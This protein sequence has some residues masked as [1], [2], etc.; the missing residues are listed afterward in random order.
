MYTER[1]YRRRTAFTLLEVLVV[2]TVISTVVGLSVLGIQ[3]AREHSNRVRCLA[4][5]KNLA[6]AV[7]LHHDAKKV[8][9]PYAT[10]MGDDIFGGWF[11]H[12]LPYLGYQDAY[13]RLVKSQK[14]NSTNGFYMVSSVDANLKGMPFHELR[15]HSDPSGQADDQPRTN[16]LANWYALT[17]Q[18]KGPYGLGQ[19]FRELEDGP[20]NVVLF[21]EGYRA[22]DRVSRI[23]MQPYPYHNFGLTQKGLPSDH[24]SYAPVDYM[25]FQVKPLNCD[26]LR[27][28]TAHSAMP[29]ALGDGSSR[30]VSGSIPASTW[31]LILK[32]RDGNPDFDW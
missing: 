7:H 4:H 15:C 16:Y 8:M 28:Q 25:M 2:F 1:E 26:K 3:A 13:D 10:G 27:T 30:F 24:P 19:P 9:P 17:K 14:N 6:L 18:E 21:A 31:K 20:S 32:P 12:L 22:C 29:V 5:L 11:V 23:A